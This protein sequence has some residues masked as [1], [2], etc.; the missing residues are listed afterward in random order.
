M[1]LC[2]EDASRFCESSDS[3]EDEC[4]GDTSDTDNISL[5]ISEHHARANYEAAGTLVEEEAD[6]ISLADNESLIDPDVDKILTNILDDLQLP[7]QISDFQRI[8]VNVLGS[9]RHLVLVSPTGSGKM[10]VPLLS[11]LVLRRK[12]GISKG[13]VI[14]TQPLS[15]IMNQKLQNKICD[16]AVL[17]MAGQVKTST[18]TDE[19]AELSCELEDLFGG[20][21]PVLIGHPE[22]FDSSMG[23]CILKELL[24]LGML[25]LVCID[26]FHQA[27]F[28]KTY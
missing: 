5:S 17:T 6:L 15:S 1:S 23:R 14:V 27:C 7:Y 10:D 22:S 3:D 24:R 2:E 28:R 16:A 11:G 4:L 19:E 13:V 20:K 8:S 12:L 18:N 9:M 26:E 21:F 25:I